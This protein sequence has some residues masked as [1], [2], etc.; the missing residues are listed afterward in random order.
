MEPTRSTSRTTVAASSTARSA[1][2][3]ALPGIVAAVGDRAE[4]LLDGG[5]RR[6]EDVVKARALGARACLVGRPWFMALAAAGEPGV[7]RML[8]LMARDIDRTLALVGVP[9][10][11]DVDANAL[12]TNRL[13]G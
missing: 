1:T 12:L 10:F 13:V 7:A 2:L 8:E 6:G 3:D 9:N 4:V 5:V 11:D